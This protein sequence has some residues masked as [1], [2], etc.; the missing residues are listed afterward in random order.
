MTTNEASDNERFGC[1][2]CDQSF[3][4]EIGMKVHRTKI[5]RSSNNTNYEYECTKCDFGTDS[6][7][8]LKYHRVQKHNDDL[9][10]EIECE[11]CST[12]VERTPSEINEKTFC[13]WECRSEYLSG[14]EQPDELVEKRAAAQRNKVE[15]ECDY[16][17]EEFLRTPKRVEKFEY[18]YCNHECK[19]KH[20][21]EKFSGSNH[22]RWSGGESGIDFIRKHIRDEGWQQTAERIREK[23]DRT[24]QMCGSKPSDRDRALDVHHIVPLIA[25]GTN[26]DELLLPLCLDCHRTAESYTWNIIDKYLIAPAD[27]DT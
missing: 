3:D 22:P 23:Y 2:D 7:R 19:G 16:C 9:F 26:A 21:S 12:V 10:Q 4:T 8:G 18:Q 11:V 27:P 13:S 5:H 6:S 1:P 14:R 25:G 24:C 15:V 17:G 20:H